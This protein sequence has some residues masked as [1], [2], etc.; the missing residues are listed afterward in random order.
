[1]RYFYNE[2]LKDLIRRRR[3]VFFNLAI[4]IICSL[5][6]ISCG[7]MSEVNSGR[8]Y[9]NNK[10]P[11]EPGKCYAKCLVH[12]KYATYEEVLLVY[13]G[14]DM[15][16][17]GVEL[18]KIIFK[19]ATTKWV[20]KKSP[21]C[22]SADPNDCLVWCLVDEPEVSKEYLIVRDTNLV[23]D[24]KRE[25]VNY[26]ELEQAGGFT[27]WKEVVCEADLNESL[28]QNI[29]LA[30]IANGYL[31]DTIP[32][33]KIGKTT[34]EALVKYQ[35]SNELPVGSLDLETLDHLGVEY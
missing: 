8:N 34:K 14:E 26:R 25:I 7:S 20:K 15:N 16:R 33:G 6:I 17:E 4:L 1:M 21:N 19:P 30:L 32:D 11:N 13:S 22:R 3:A 5:F 24:F 23:K 2:N 18:E 29:Q 31:Q 12:D 10:L 28:Y 27:E 35:K 9:S